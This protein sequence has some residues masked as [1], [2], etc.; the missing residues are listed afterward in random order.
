VTPPRLLLGGHRK[1]GGVIRL[2]PDEALTNGLAIAEGIESALSLAQA[3]QPVWALID[4]GNLSKFPPLPGVE[5]LTIAVDHD[6]AGQSAADDCAAQWY[7]A[8]AEVHTVMADRIGHDLND[9]VRSG[10]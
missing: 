7:D 3:F 8:G 2:W 5:S 4:S 6:D 1:A 10:S 9:L